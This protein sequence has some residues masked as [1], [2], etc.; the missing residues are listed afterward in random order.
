LFLVA[1]DWYFCSHRLP[2]AVAARQAG[3]DVV[4][5]TRVTAHKTVIEQAGLRIVPLRRLSRSSLN[6][7]LELAALGELVAV[8]RKERPHL[9]HQVA[10]KPVIYGSI[11]A[12]FANVSSMVNALGGLGFVFSSRSFLARLLKPLLVGAFR[13]IFNNPGNRLILQNT[14][15]LTVVTQEAGVEQRNIR[16]IRSAGVDLSQYAVCEPPSRVPVVLLASR[17]LWDK[18]VGEFVKAA[19]VLRQQGVSARFVLAGEPDSENPSSISRKQLQE[20]NDS[21]ET[22]WW[23]HRN[24]MPEVLSQARIVC[25]PSYYG[26]GI[27]KILVEAMA[28]ARPIVTTDMPGCN[29]VVRTGINGLLVKP[30]D[31]EDL[32]RAIKVLLLDEEKC[33][34]MGRAGR[35][36]AEKEY[37]LSRVVVETMAIYGEL[38]N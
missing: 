8:Y 29:E 22:E 24:D 1:E 4:V 27:P 17:M 21:G 6:P 2:I 26:E 31:P 19:S 15:D 32:A 16:L 18:G 7:F 33:Q 34:Q 10:L 12:R 9:V 28:S 38:L 23:G 30:R 14:N 5:V 20:W 35:Q 13:L 36:I 11:A 37:A 3:H 25:L